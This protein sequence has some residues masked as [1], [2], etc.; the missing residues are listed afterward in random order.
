MIY[1]SNAIPTRSTNKNVEVGATIFV[2][3]PE[4]TYRNGE[5]VWY[6]DGKNCMRG[7]HCGGTPVTLTVKTATKPSIAGRPSTAILFIQIMETLG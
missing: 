5:L 1:T 2:R 4:L 6:P 3:A 7:T